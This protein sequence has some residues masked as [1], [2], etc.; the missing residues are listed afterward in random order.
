MP[1]LPLALESLAN[2]TYRNHKIL[3]WDDCSTDGSLQELERW[4]PDRIPGRIFSGKSLRLG[5]CLAFLVAQADTELCARM[6]GDDISL[7]HRLERQVAFMTE[8][9]E[10]DVLGGYAQLVDLEGKDLYMWT[11]ATGDSDTRWQSRF[12]AQFSHPA[13]MYRRSAVL[14]AGNYPDCRA[15][16]A[17]L[18]TR[19]SVMKFEFRN[20]PEPLIQYRRTTTSA[21]GTVEDWLPSNREFAKFCASFMFPG[22]PDPRQAMELWEATRPNEAKVKTELR[23]LKALK[24]TAVAHA[25]QVGKPDSYFLNCDYFRAQLYWVNRRIME[26]FGLGPLL[27]LR[28]RLR[29][30]AAAS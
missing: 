7:P 28:D 11:Y 17:A 25:R 24:Q 18:W 3:A 14:A 8:H 10:V 1:Y 5:P 29:R 9:P 23:H 20:L 30:K 16:D 26:G 21:T 12:N 19:M 13:V 27:R 15:E 6:D 2:Q 22:V 4:I